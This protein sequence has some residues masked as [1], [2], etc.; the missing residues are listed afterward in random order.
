MRLNRLW[1]FI[2]LSSAS[3]QNDSFEPNCPF[4][5][6]EAEHRLRRDIL[7]NKRNPRVPDSKGIVFTNDALHNGP[8]GILVS[9]PRPMDQVIGKPTEAELGAELEAA[10]LA[11][12]RAKIAATEQ[13]RRLAAIDH[14]LELQK[15]HELEHQRRILEKAQTEANILRNTKPQIVA[16]KT[17]PVVV[18]APENVPFRHHIKIMLNELQGIRQRELKFIRSAQKMTQLDDVADSVIAAHPPGTP[19]ARYDKLIH[20][21]GAGDVE[22]EIPV[23]PSNGSFFIASH[24]PR[25]KIVSREL[26]QHNMHTTSHVGATGETHFKA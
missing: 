21:A 22:Y 2:L 12:K 4:C 10:A 7:E 11:E 26:K 14:D 13:E 20:L 17:I 5:R 24:N 8:G 15:V 25:E 6:K 1:A 16:K 3:L 18:F 9:V 23:N 19:P